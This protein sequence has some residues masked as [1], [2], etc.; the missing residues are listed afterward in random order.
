MSKVD[1]S[2]LSCNL[3]A[4]SDCTHN[5][6]KIID[7]HFDASGFIDEITEARNSMIRENLKKELDALRGQINNMQQRST[8]LKDRNQELEEN[9]NRLSKSKDDLENLQQQK[10]DLFAVII[11]DIKNPAE[12]N[13][14][15]F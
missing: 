12:R 6:I 11:H 15:Y 1:N 4:D 5:I 8:E 14:A 3:S 7:D 13:C 10:D 2:Y 9:V